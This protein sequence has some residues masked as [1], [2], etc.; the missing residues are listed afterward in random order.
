MRL[1]LI[2][3]IV[4]ARLSWAQ[5]KSCE[6]IAV[7]GHVQVR[8]ANALQWELLEKGRI[9]QERETLRSDKTATARLRTP[10]GKIFALPE[11]AQI[12]IREL[13]WRDRNQVV[14]ELTALEM[15]KL[16]AKKDS[17]PKPPAAFILHGALPDSAMPAPEAEMRDYLHREERGALALFAQGYYAGFILK[18]NR[19]LSA[20]SNFASEPAE[21][22]LIK[23]YEI[24]GM[25]FRME[26]ARERYQR[27]W[28]KSKP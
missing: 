24:M 7:A 6:V 18:W 4:S 20:F 8:A 16:P 10:E 27:N 13:R 26:Q 12:E 22:A 1:F 21:A 3:L 15:Q 9:L 23:A 25:P 17:T 2:F 28:V 5:N 14:L 19:L 11:N